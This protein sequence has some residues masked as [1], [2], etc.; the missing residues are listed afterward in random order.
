MTTALLDLLARCQ[1]FHRLDGAQLAA[2]AGDIRRQP[3]KRGQT[4]LRRGASATDRLTYLI[5]GSAELRRSFFDRVQLNAGEGAALRPLD[6]LLAEG[7]QV[8]AQ[9]DGEIA[10]VARELLE[11]LAAEHSSD[12]A[13]SALAEEDFTEDFRIS[14]GEVEVDWMSR[15]LQSSLAHQLPARNIEKLLA[16][17]EV[18][19]AAKGDTIVRR[20]ETGDALYVLVRGLAL[21]RTDGDGVFEGR[22]FPLIAG[23]YFGEEALVA[24]TVRSASVVMEADG[25]VARL[26]RADFDELVRPHLIRLAN[27]TLVERALLE[28]EDGNNPLVLDVRLPVEYRRG[29]LPNS[30]N[31]PIAALR[32][33][34]PDLDQQRPVLV[35]AHGGCRSELAVFLLRQAGFDA[36]L[37]PELRV[38]SPV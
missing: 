12:Y 20:G 1:P 34:L 31:I 29:C 19:D 3:F 6:D 18:R 26:A 2:C 17:L 5:A 8:V 38:S 24:D 15:F 16:R 14:D 35:T 21:V 22:E 27:D 33:A 37:L 7:G 10:L 36:Y 9:A 32:A 28:R 13:V 11:R 30:R 23:D 4:V 25:A